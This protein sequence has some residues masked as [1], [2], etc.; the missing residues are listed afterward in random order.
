[1]GEL[2]ELPGRMAAVESQILQLRGEMRDGFSAI[3][4]RLATHEQRFDDLTRQMR[5][6]HE[7]L[8]RHMR[9]LHEDVVS[10]MSVTKEAPLTGKGRRRRKR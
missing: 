8:G 4:A 3:H 5:E 1:M 6:G 9:L 10:K 2:Q 7:E